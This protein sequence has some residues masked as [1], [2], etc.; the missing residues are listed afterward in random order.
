MH[1]GRERLDNTPSVQCSEVDLETFLVHSLLT[2]LLQPSVSQDAILSILAS[3]QQSFSINDTQCE[4]AFMKQNGIVAVEQVLSAHASSSVIVG[5]VLSLI[6]EVTKTVKYAQILE[7][8][9]I[10]P[11]CIQVLLRYQN[12]KTLVKAALRI[13]RAL[14]IYSTP[15]LV[16]L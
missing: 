5:A 10:I 8:S 7:H 1:A 11:A 9:N 16:S 14:C 15:A 3:L 13:T 12:N 4:V 2:M 6:E